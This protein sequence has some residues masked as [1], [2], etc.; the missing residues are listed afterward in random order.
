MYKTLDEIPE[1]ADEL[2]A[3][4]S[5][6][7]ESMAFLSIIKANDDDK[8]DEEKRGEEYLNGNIW[9]KTDLAMY[10]LELLVH[11]DFMEHITKDLAVPGT[12][13]ETDGNIVIDVLLEFA[14]TIAG[15]L[16][17]SVEPLT[18]A[19]TLEIPE[20]DVGRKVNKDAFLT[21]KYVTDGDNYIITVAITKI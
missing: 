4:V 18:G 17:R 12:A 13:S 10:S 9:I 11:E 19:F 3:S 20:F 15:S 8:E 2:Y 21:E 1:L 16:M 6:S 7:L 14:N 5:A